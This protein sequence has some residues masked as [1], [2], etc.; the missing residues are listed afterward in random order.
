MSDGSR[1]ES[2]TDAETVMSVLG[3]EYGLTAS[4]GVH[5]LNAVD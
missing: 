5:R 2:D 4:A 1:D 3:G